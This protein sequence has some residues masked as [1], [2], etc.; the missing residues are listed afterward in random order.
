MITKKEVPQ[1]WTRM[2]ES[3]LEHSNAFGFVAVRDGKVVGFVL[4]EV[5]GEGF[6]VPQSGW[7]EVVGV[8]P[9]AM[10]Q[11]VGKSMIEKLFAAFRTKGIANVYT[12]VRW[13]AADMLSFFKAVGFGRSDFINLTRQL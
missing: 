4:G 5:K 12:T 13:D 6:G 1:T 7:I 2:V 8:D 3:H 9:Q 11:G 10:G